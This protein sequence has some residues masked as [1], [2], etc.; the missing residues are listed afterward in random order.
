MHFY[1]H[2]IYEGQVLGESKEKFKTCLF[3]ITDQPTNSRKDL[4]VRALEAAPGGSVS[5]Q[6]SLQDHCFCMVSAR[7]HAHT[8]SL[9]SA[10]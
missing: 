4:K 10:L 2:S 6:N 7:L 3:S 1:Q 8:Y 5:L 9:S